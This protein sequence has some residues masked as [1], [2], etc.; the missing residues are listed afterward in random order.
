MPLPPEACEMCRVTTL[1][2]DQVPKVD[3]SIDFTADFFDR[4]SY[5]T[6]SGQ[7]NAEIYA[8]ALGKVYTF[9]PTGNAEF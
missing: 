9:G 6:V 7:L 4:P 1:N 5:L 2:L 8:C 3:G